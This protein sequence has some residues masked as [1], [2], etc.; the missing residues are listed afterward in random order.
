MENN[1]FL[2]YL[3]KQ[4]NLLKLPAQIVTAF[5]KLANLP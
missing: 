1:A 4:T 2:E 5:N 3:S